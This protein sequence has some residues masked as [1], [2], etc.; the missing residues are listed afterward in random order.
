M[1][2]TPL[3]FSQA[4]IRHGMFKTRLRAYLL[5]GSGDVASFTD[6]KACSLGTWLKEVTISNKLA[7]NAILE[8]SYLHEEAHQEAAKV[9]RLYQQNKVEEARSRLALIESKDNEIHQALIQLQKQAA[10]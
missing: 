10:A 1:S 2:S 4:W 9:I 6:A 8:V 5:G 3:D 7:S